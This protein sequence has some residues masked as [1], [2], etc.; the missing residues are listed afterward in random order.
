MWDK[1]SETD[2]VLPAPLPLTWLEAER[3]IAMR[4]KGLVSH[5]EVKG[6]NEAIRLPCGLLDLITDTGRGIPTPIHT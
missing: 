6:Q 5:A 4:V 1:S 2:T 3:T